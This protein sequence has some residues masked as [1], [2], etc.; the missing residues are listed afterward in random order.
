M[1]RLLQQMKQDQGEGDD[2]EAWHTQGRPARWADIAAGVSLTARRCALLWCW[3]RWALVFLAGEATL[4]SGVHCLLRL[5]LAVRMRCSAQGQAACS[6]G[7]GVAA[8][9]LPR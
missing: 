2:D 8:T 5:L 4:L 7:G 1:Q 6:G 9:R 3:V